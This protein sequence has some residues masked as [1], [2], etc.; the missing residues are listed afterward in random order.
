V[1]RREIVWGSTERPLVETKEP[2][3]NNLNN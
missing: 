2:P 1:M 3:Q